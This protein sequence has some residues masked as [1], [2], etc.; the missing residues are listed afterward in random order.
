VIVSKLKSAEE[1]KCLLELELQKT[2]EIKQAHETL[3][4]VN[5]KLQSENEDLKSK[6]EEK[7]KVVR[8]E[9]EQKLDRLKT[10]MV[11]I[12]ISCLS[13]KGKLCVFIMTL[14]EG[15]TLSLL[16]IPSILT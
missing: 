3:L 10:K 6:I 1:G 14:I 13:E 8:Q 9:Y 7:S 12:V 11:G 5:Y 15:C 2:S 4:E 16:P